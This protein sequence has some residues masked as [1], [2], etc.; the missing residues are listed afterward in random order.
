[1]KELFPGL[2]QVARVPSDGRSSTI[3]IVGEGKTIAAIDCGP[4]QYYQTLKDELGDEGVDLSAL[5]DI[6]VTH[7]HSDH[8]EA[9]AL[10]RRDG[11]TPNVHVGELDRYAV[12]TGDYFGTAGFFYR[13]HTLPVPETLSI[14]DGYVESF[15]KVAVRAFEIPSHTMGSI[16]YVVENDGLKVGILGDAAWGGWHPLIGSDLDKWEESIEMVQSLDLTHVS[17][18]HGPT[19]LIAA[20]SHL[21]KLRRQIGKYANAYDILPP[22]NFD[23]NTAEPAYE[24]TAV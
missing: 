17:F 22:I 3:F 11:Y 8:Y 9:A 13:Q 4:A 14:G 12:E 10:F 23:Q 16:A 24:Y 20:K 1:M 7:G 5:T 2:R 18:G 19:E 21:R 6:F 15:G